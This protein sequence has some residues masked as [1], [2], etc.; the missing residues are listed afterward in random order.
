MALG[1]GRASWGV[2]LPADLV[3]TAVDGDPAGGKRDRFLTAAQP[4][5]NPV[6][7]YAELVQGEC[8]HDTRATG[9][10]TEGHAI[11]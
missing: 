10:L 8:N 2:R 3:A 5:V 4:V 6:T 1:R 11:G 9:S 7:R